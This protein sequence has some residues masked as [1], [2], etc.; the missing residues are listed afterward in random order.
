MI[1]V[2]EKSVAE[3]SIQ[4]LVVQRDSLITRNHELVSRNHYLVK[5]TTSMNIAD[6]IFADGIFL[7]KKIGSFSG[8]SKPTLIGSSFWAVF[9]KANDFGTC[10]RFGSVS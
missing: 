7:H 1:A 3:K 6:G 10:F 4:K 2:A 9:R 5:A 8:S